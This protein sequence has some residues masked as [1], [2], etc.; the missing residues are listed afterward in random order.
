MSS[1]KPMD[2]IVYDQTG[3]I[4]SGRCSTTDLHLQAQAGETV[5]EGIINQERQKIHNGQVID[6]TQE[7]I[8]SDRVGIP[9]VNPDDEIIMIKQKDWDAVLNRLA[10]LEGNG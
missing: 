2:Y 10:K 3:K 8:D 6:K 4:R 1:T 9:P 7:E 5:I